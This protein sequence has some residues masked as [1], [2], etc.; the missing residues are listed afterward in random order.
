MANAALARDVQAADRGRGEPA[1]RV[2]IVSTPRSGNTW[3]WHLLTAL[4]DVPG[5]A[6]HSPLEVAWEALPPSCVLQMHWRRTDSFVERLRQHRFRVVVMARH[7]LD[8]LISILHFSLH[9]RATAKWLE[10][11][12]GNERGIFG[13]MPR[14]TAFREYVKGPRAAALLAVSAEWWNAAGCLGIRYEDLNQDPEATL[15]RAIGELGG[16]PRIGVPQAIETATIPKLRS[17]WQTQHYF[18]LGKIGLWRCLLP[19]AEV[20]PLAAHL[21]PNLSHLGYTTEPDSS[22]SALQADAN[23]IN[24]VW[25]DLAEELQDL[26][27]TKKVLRS[28]RQALE[29]SQAHARCLHEAGQRT[30]ADLAA[31]RAECAEVRDSLGAQLTAARAE[32]DALKQALIATQQSQQWALQQLETAQARLASLEDIGPLT[33]QLARKVRRIS[34]E[35]P[36][37]A[38]TVKQVLPAFQTKPR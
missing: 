6:V 25:S 34:A 36:R 8:V 24:L 10:G 27:V 17:R 2:A 15:Q 28:T 37:L 12:G 13:A 21:T 19:R 38:R 31:A 3:L 22:L 32:I 18:W 33:L 20:E 29:E 14:S 35:Y 16:A 26:S 1:L 30:E 23:W 11:E 9:D 4:Y 5:I 7:P